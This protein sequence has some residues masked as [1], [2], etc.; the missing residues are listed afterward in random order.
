MKKIGIIAVMAVTMLLFSPMSH[1]DPFLVCDPQAGVT[2]Y[3]ITGD[4]TDTVTAEP[5]GSIKRDMAGTA[6]G[7]YNI[8]VK[9]CNLWGCSDPSP[10][11]FSKS[12]CGAPAGIG[13]SAQ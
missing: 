3:E 13:L 10:F 4:I 1:A 9:A 12:Q 8:D 6:D 11:G 5:D 2:H 7:T